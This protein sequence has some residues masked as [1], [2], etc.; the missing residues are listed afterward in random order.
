MRARAL[1]S[2]GKAAG[3]VRHARTVPTQ[4]CELVRGHVSRLRKD[5]LHRLEQPTKLACIEHCF[6]IEDALGFAE[7]IPRILAA[8]E[9][10]DPGEAVCVP[11]EKR[12]RITHSRSTAAEAARRHIIDDWDLRAQR[13]PPG[14]A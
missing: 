7:N 1:A 4:R 6:L 3:K 5:N 13:W 12:L 9:V 11:V 14:Q 10:Q 2:R 8:S